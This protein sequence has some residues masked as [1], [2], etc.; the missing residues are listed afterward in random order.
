MN[1]LRLV[2]V[3]LVSVPTLDPW[4][5]NF[6]NL[7]CHAAEEQHKAATRLLKG[8]ACPARLQLGSTCSLLHFLPKLLIV[9][10]PEIG[11]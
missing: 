5:A 6:G 8:D 7:L 10:F 11:G 1:L 4:R 3:D 9:V 2:L